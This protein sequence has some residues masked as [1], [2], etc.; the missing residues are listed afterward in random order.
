MELKERLVSLRKKKGISQQELAEALNVSRQA[1]S[2]WEVG[3]SAPSVENLLALSRLFH[4]PVCELTDTD[5]T[6]EEEILGTEPA[7]CAKKMK[8]TRSQSLVRAL[9]CLLAAA[10]VVGLLTVIWR[11]RSRFGGAAPAEQN[12]VDM[13][14]L[15]EERVGDSDAI[16]DPELIIRGRLENAVRATSRIE[17][18]ISPKTIGKEDLF[19]TYCYA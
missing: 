18:D 6:G 10:A 2:R 12:I 15:K 4:V 19:R 14:N 13:E 8:W 11:D 3:A 9:G 7:E 17:W 5:G 1:V 16:V